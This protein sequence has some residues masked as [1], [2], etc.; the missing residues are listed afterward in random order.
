MLTPNSQALSQ[1]NNYADSNDFAEGIGTLK[2]N[3]GH[4]Y[5]MVFNTFLWV[6]FKI[7]DDY[8]CHLYMESPPPPPPQDQGEGHV[9]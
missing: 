9:L 2:I 4:I 7:S 8:L 1:K 6:P 3:V 5:K